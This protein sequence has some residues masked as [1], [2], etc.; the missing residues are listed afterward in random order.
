MSYKLLF[1][2]QFGTLGGGQRVL[3][4]TLKSLDRAQYQTM[5][6]L[7]TCGAFRERLL[8]EGI[9]V[10]DLPLGSYHSGKKTPLDMV[11]FFF[12]SLYCAV[13]LTGWVFRHRLDLLF[14]N[15]PR[16]FICVTLA[17][18][19]TRRP[20]IWH[21][22][23]VLPQGVELSLLAIFSRWVH[24]IVVC[25][26]AAAQPLLERRP[27]IQ[28]KIRLIYNPVP[29]LKQPTPG[30]VDTLR[31][32]FGVQPKHVCIGILGRVTP[33]KGQWHFL[34]AARLVLQQAQEARFFVIGSPA[35]DKSDQAYY[36]QL[37]LIVERTGMK[38]SVFFVEHQ[39]EV[40]SFLAMMDVVV[41]AS[42]GPE[43]LP[44]TVIEA[45]SM[46][47]VVIAPASGGIVEIVEDGKTGLFAR[48]DQPEKL[49]AAMLKLIHEPD[50]R[51]SLG[52]SAQER[53]SRHHSREKFG[54]AIQ[55]ILKSCL[56]QEG[57]EGIPASPEA[58]R[59]KGA[60]L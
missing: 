11:R 45:M 27:G 3:L 60:I 44:Q 16:T 50:I 26:Q 54:E 56:T 37:R 33:F 49:A 39:R 5:V 43:A 10:M 40:E 29:R 18:W 7:G 19:L 38:N 20:V 47:K 35:A 22:H 31:E 57:V 12:R 42:Q 17:G 52:R 9:P 34:Q 15:G 14:A 41:V 28:S 46:G 36:I 8:D 55:S 30:D 48:A 13:V 1:V 24:S 58:A 51:K 4:E 2:D 21:L 23:N 6:A 59:M 53:M 32:S 25:S